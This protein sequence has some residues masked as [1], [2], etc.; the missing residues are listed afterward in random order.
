MDNKKVLEGEV[1]CV[2]GK[3]ENHTQE[4]MESMVTENGGTVSSSVTKKTTMLVTGD[5]VGAT[6]LNK[7]KELGIRIVDQSDFFGMVHPTDSTDDDSEANSENEKHYYQLV[8]SCRATVVCGYT[9]ADNWNKDLEAC[10]GDYEELFGKYYNNRETADLREIF[11][12][13]DDF[14]L[15]VW[16]EDGN[17]VTQI[18]DFDDIKMVDTG[19]KTSLLY[20]DCTYLLGYSTQEDFSCSL[21]LETDGQFDPQKLYFDKKSTDLGLDEEFHID[22]LRYKGGDL[23]LEEELSGEEYFSD[24]YIAEFDKKNGWKRTATGDYDYQETQSQPFKGEVVCVS[25]KFGEFEQKDVEAMV[26]KNGATISS[27][28]TKKTTLLIIGEKVSAAKLTKASELGVRIMQEAEFYKT[29]NML[30]PCKLEYSSQHK[31]LVDFEIPMGVTIIGRAAFIKCTNLRSVKIPDSV[32]KIEDYAFYHCTGLTS[33]EIPDS[34]KEIGYGAFEGCTGLTSVEIPNS[35]KKI[36][37]WLHEGSFCGCTGLKSVVIPASVT[38]IED[39]AFSGCAG[40][41]FFVDEGNPSYTSLNGLLLTKDKK[42]LLLGAVCGN[43]VVPS[44]VEKIGEY[45]F[46]GCT[47]LTSVEIPSSVKV[48]GGGVNGGSFSGCTGLTSVVIPSSVEKI[49]EKTFSGCTGLTSVEIPSS[50]KLIGENAFERCTGLTSV[51]I[52]NSVKKIGEYAFYGCTGLTSVEILASVKEIG[53]G[54]FYG[55]TGLTS[56]EIP[57]SV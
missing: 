35:V 52:P 45:A 27:S 39:G 11:L 55:C 50:V 37:G 32:T 21:S 9:L 23:E 24:L 36:A 3:F 7:A 56:V 42:V 17:D 2:S 15:E 46:Y 40:L 29:V 49:G 5:K 33:I 8:V 28:V 6:K 1:V 16:D 26:E 53:Y 25:G 4:E 20:K 43:V 31:N 47:G 22:D 41:S 48:I 38:E 34:V 18:E 51:E 10:D 14:L 44:S 54:A 57:N 30:K 12:S 13:D 19:G